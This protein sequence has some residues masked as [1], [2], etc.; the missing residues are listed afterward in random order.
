[1]GQQSQKIQFIV[2]VGKPLT[3]HKFNIKK[4]VFG[5]KSR[6]HPFYLAE[7]SG[8]PR[9]VRAD[10]K[11]SAGI[12]IGGFCRIGDEKTTQSEDQETEKNA[13]FI[14]A[15]GGCIYKKIEDIAFYHE[16]R[17]LRV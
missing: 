6:L 3:V 17:Y 15:I 11:H 14:L 2:T 8:K 7:E 4:N 13:A 12:F 16:M 9:M 10:K 1:M 5:R